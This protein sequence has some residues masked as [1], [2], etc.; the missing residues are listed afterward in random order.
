MDGLEVLRQLRLRDPSIAVIMITGNQDIALA[1]AAQNLGTVDYMFKPL[2]LDHLDRAILAGIEARALTG[3]LRSLP[4]VRLP[5]SRGGGAARHPAW[6]QMTRRA[7][8]S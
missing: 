8:S 4:S 6:R 1:R 3:S 7:F 2:D 5:G